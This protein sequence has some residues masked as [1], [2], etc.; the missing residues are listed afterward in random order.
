MTFFR[1]PG[2]EFHGCWHTFECP[3]YI[4]EEIFPL[5]IQRKHSTVSGI[6][7]RSSLLVAGRLGT[8]SYQRRVGN[9]V[10]VMRSNEDLP[11]DQPF[12]QLPLPVQ[13]FSSGLGHQTCHPAQP[14]RVQMCEIRYWETSL[15]LPD[16]GSKGKT[17][18][19]TSCQFH[20]LP[21]SFKA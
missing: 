10:V 8:C 14:T 4:L 2:P 12:F 11:D 19:K 1:A 7:F 18:F 15:D 21:H 16:A 20:Q 3:Q 5:H 13:G 6:R 17:H 9:D